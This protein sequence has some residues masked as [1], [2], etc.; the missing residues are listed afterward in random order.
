MDVEIPKIKDPDA[1][2]SFKLFVS[3]LI[4]IYVQSWAFFPEGCVVCQ[5]I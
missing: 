4:C 3:Q 1:Y 2:K 5:Y